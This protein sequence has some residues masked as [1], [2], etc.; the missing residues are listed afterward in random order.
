MDFEEAAKKSW[1]SFS[2]M[3]RFVSEAN[4][5]ENASWRL[6]YMQKKHGVAHHGPAHA[7]DGASD[8]A[9]SYATYVEKPPVCVY[10]EMQAASLSCNGCCHDA[11]CISC[12]KLIH[13]KGNLATHT[14]I[15]IKEEKRH[16]IETKSVTSV[17]SSV[18]DESSDERESKDTLED[19]DLRRPRLN[20][21]K[22]KPWETKMDM[23]IQ[24]LMVNSIHSEGD[25][26]VHNIDN[27]DS[28][29][30]ADSAASFFSDA[31]NSA[32]FSG[33]LGEEG[34]DENVP[35]NHDALQ[36]SPAQVAPSPPPSTSSLRPSLSPLP[37]K[38]SGS[39]MSGSPGPPKSPFGMFKSKSRRNPVCAN[40]N[41]SHI[42]I[43]CPLLE[44]SLSSPAFGMHGSASPG[45]GPS[46]GVDTMLRKC[47][48][49]IHNDNSANSTHAFL[50]DEISVR[51]GSLFS[52]SLFAGP[53]IGVD[54]GS[55]YNYGMISIDENHSSAAE[56]ASPM[57][58]ALPTAPVELE[59]RKW[60]CQSW[61]MSCLVTDLPT[62]VYETLRTTS[63]SNTDPSGRY[64]GDSGMYSMS[65]WVYLKTTGSKW[66][67]RYLVLYRNNLW[68]FLDERESSRPVGFAN[69]TDGS[70]HV[71]QKTTVEF[72]VKY[73]RYASTDPAR[74]EVWLQCET[75]ED[76][77]LW[78][79]TILRA[80]RL[81][82]DDLFDLTPDS[83][84]TSLENYELGKGR[85]SVVRRACRKSSNCN[86]SP[87]KPGREDCAL[88]IVD[89]EV[90][91]D[92]VANETERED[93]V[94]REILTQSLLT[95]RSGNAYC[96]VIRLLS[97]FETRSHLV[98]ELEL[99]QEGDL[100]EEIVS[101]SAVSETRASSLVASLVRAIDYCLRNGVAHRDIKLSNLALDYSSGP[102][103]KRISVLKIADFGMAAFI[104]RDG[105]LRGRCGT[106]GFVA[107]EI[108]TAGKGESYPCG[109]DMF[110]AGV[111]AYT[112][113]CGY[114]PF[115]G[116]TD[117][118]LI[119]MNK[120]V[121]F[122]FEEPEW[123]SISI[124][125]KDLILMLMEKDTTKR[126][127]PADA[128]Q[129]PFLRDASLALDDTLRYVSDDSQI[130]L[131]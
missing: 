99:M 82:I 48:T 94:I 131:F 65:G 124:E 35:R 23:L 89:K 44:T 25:I 128:L 43:D 1:Q 49:T 41:G 39:D 122:E 96:P 130:R 55:S 72:I 79:E 36:A 83:G 54:D 107:P 123:S 21:S 126:L 26:S 116:V 30:T 29:G 93:T 104:H 9:A 3:K 11:Y 50:G 105:T 60:D 15:K 114:E 59:P 108:L 109:V 120:A 102:N 63:K 5:L 125:A 106:P 13:K 46:S 20:S 19:L 85:F 118:E 95:V 101:K 38:R 97:L 69:L 81:T 77:E 40:C 80:T 127:S 98:M 58:L 86:N 115:F 56:D 73:H 14:A 53:S 62:D 7:A 90:F 68:E 84:S 112:M 45:T 12:F 42:M 47:F 91:W 37:T 52:Q 28:L 8:P 34:W 33:A 113:L 111:V 6:W 18:D 110:S 24:R 71:Q 121:E 129:H 16:G 119:Q 51:G 4:R 57:L 27:R 78:R 17:M 32:D 88:K 74:N 66:C 92:L 2:T 100:H 75:E 67:K 70:V 64:L 10:C 103:G 22:I 61:M 76:T 31:T 117:E 87:P